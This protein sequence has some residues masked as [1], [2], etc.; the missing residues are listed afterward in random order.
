MADVA[1]PGLVSDGSFQGSGIQ[2][3]IDS[4][5]ASAAGAYNTYVAGQTAQLQTQTQQY[6]A[7]TNQ[8]SYIIIGA[9]IV[10]IFLIKG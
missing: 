5:A 10:A 4:I 9:I 7:Q 3:T 2:Q 8:M 1:E 6:V